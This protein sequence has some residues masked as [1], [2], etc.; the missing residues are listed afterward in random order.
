MNEHQPRIF[1]PPA[2]NRVAT[3]ILAEMQAS[4][5]VAGIRAFDG[6]LDG[7]IIYGL[8]LREGGA[9]PAL[10]A[11]GAAPV[12]TP[13]AVTI[14]V[15]AERL[16]RPFETVRRYANHLIDLGVCRRTA[17]GVIALPEAT[18]RP[19][20]RTLLVTLHDLL[21]RLIEDMAG[22]GMPLPPARHDL[23]Y[24]PRVGLTA[25]LDMLLAAVEYS[26]RNY[27]SW[28]EMVLL[29][30]VMCANA[31][32][33]TYDIDIS[34]TY[35]DYAT[36]VPARLRAPI[37]IATAARTLGI[38]YS[39]ARRHAEGMLADGRMTRTSRGL[40]VSEAW[41]AGPALLADREQSSGKSREIFGR[42]AMGGF[43]F[44]TPARAYVAGRPPLLKFV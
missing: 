19:A 16:L 13:R 44:D 28:F 38:P 10:G 31:R 34:M 43:P 41:L 40:L 5:S 39:T 35:P 24:D 29:E 2:R 3:R 21:V 23:A 37:R 25:A 30:T 33:F 6:D 15:L 32:P 9:L 1:P 42:L 11:R 36:P 27:A 20:V 12:A 17:G 7:S 26:A 18:A 4:A 14:N 8:L 22:F